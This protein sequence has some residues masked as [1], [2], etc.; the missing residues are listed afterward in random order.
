MMFGGGGSCSTRRP[1]K[2]SIV[3]STESSLIV[4]SKHCLDMVGEREKMVVK[5]SKSNPAIKGNKYAHESL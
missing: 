2:S 3:S 5:L 1:K 4:M